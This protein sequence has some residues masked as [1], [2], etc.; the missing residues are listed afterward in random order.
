MIVIGELINGTRRPIAEAIAKR[1]REFIAD[2]AKRQE[3]AGADYIDCNAGT[4]GE[5][6]VDDLV[7]LVEVV[8]EGVRIPISLDSPNPMA[9]GRALEIYS[10]P[11]PLI[12]SVTAEKE[13]IEQV[14]PLVQ[15]SGASVIALL[16]GDAGMP[17]DAA[18]RMANAD[19]LVGNLLDAGIEP[20]RVFI[21][22]VVVPLG[23]DHNAGTWVLDTIVALRQDF[24]DC[25][26]TGGIS[27]V[28][29]G[30]PNRRLLNRVFAVM[31]VARG[32]DSAVIDPLDRELMAALIAAESL[33]GRD[34]WCMNYLHAYRQGL[35]E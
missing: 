10:G 14:V 6:E 30:L 8:Q 23:T 21:D 12:N 5:K 4:T 13:R 20:T 16:L 31:C 17:A 25:H 22:P 35:L 2:L 15:Q 33:A 3:A 18:Q 27:N 29:Y 34:E 1:D 19:V 24:G 26:I 11:P 32:L 9:L 28:S 7:W